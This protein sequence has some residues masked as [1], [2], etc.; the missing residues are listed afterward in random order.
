MEPVPST[1]TKTYPQRGPLQQFRFAAATAFHCFR[2]GVA[3]KSKLLTVYGGDWSRRLCNGC[4][5]R[6]L[7]LYK[8][9]AGTATDDEKA[10]ELAALLVS[11]VSVDDQQEAE[12]CLLVSESRA[13]YLSPEAFR[14]L[15]TAE[16]LA[17]KLRSEPELEWSPVTIGLCKAVELEVVNSIIRP[18]A[19]WA[20]AEDL[21]DDKKDKDL[22]RI[23]AFCAEPNR[24]PPELGVFAHFLQTVIHSQR[25]RETSTLIGAFLRLTTDWIG[26]QWLLDPSGL[27]QSLAT[28]TRDFRNRAAHIDELAEDDYRRCRELVMGSEGVLW[29][30]EMSV[31]KYR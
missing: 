16:Y 14:F 24:K 17:A 8:I 19:Q 21:A 31:E 23:A 26:S 2:C 11:L 27:H 30:L 25:R 3:K 20:A 15:A 5:G 28:L 10:E 13:K 7:S 6:L 9:K 29:K 18:L 4:Y 1:I 22:G 12:R